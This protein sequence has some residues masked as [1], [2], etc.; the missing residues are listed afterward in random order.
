MALV[1]DLPC[2]DMLEYSEKYVDLGMPLRMALST[3]KLIDSNGTAM[4][5]SAHEDCLDHK[6]RSRVLSKI[7]RRTVGSRWQPFSRCSMTETERTE[8]WATRGCSLGSQVRAF[9]F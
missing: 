3:A 6:G 5:P 2:V 9:P 8:G 4:L 7:M 1:K